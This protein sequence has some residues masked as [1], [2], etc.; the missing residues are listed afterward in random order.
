MTEIIS[1]F[2]IPTDKA[3]ILESPN[4]EKKVTGNEKCQIE[5]ARFKTA[6]QFSEKL[7]ANHFCILPLRCNNYNLNGLLTEIKYAII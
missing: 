4:K 7:S 6:H 1:K 5:T 3:I 2:L